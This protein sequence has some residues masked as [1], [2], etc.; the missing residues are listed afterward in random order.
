MKFKKKVLSLVIAGATGC[1]FLAVAAS[2]F[3]RTDSYAIGPNST[4]KIAAFVTGE[5]TIYL[6]TQPSAGGNVTI[7]LSG[8]KSASADFPY[9]TSRSPW[10]VTGVVPSSTLTIEGKA[11]S[12]GTAGNLYTYS[13]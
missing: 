13:K 11:G 7:T 2:A 10:K 4:K 9:Y 1:M 5:S 3:S 6:D 12:S 8:A